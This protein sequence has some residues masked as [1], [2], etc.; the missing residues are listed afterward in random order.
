M[1]LKGGIGPAT[2][3]RGEFP[4]KPAGHH[5]RM[6][7]LDALRGFAVLWMAAFHFC[8]DLNHLGLLRPRQFFLGDPF[9][10]WQ[11]AAIVTTFVFCAGLSMAVALHQ[12]QTWPR[13]WRRWMQVA[14]CA[15]LVSLGSALMFPNSWISFGVLHGLAVMLLLARGLATRWPQR[16]ALW[17]VLAAVALALPLLVQHRAFDTPYTHWVGLVTHPPITEDWVPVLPWLGVMLAGLAAGHWGLQNRPQWLSG[18]L[19]TALRPL[20]TLGRWSL[21]F[22]MVHQPVFLGALMGGRS[23][24]LW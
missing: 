13:F 1:D 20:A 24:G 10:T 23:L 4:L 7:R 16:R 14:A 11:R 3:A 6:A 19:P 21:S 9:W 15:V 8:F 12:G 5:A 2:V 18:P 22:Y 17:L